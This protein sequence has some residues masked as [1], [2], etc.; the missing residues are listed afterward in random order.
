M[1]YHRNNRGG[2]GHLLIHLNREK[3]KVLSQL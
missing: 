3:D 2:S 1:Q